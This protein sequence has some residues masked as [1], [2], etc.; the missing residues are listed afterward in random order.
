MSDETR[1]SRREVLGRAALGAFLLAP[2]VAA[3]QEDKPVAVDTGAFEK[4]LA[5]PLDDA[6]KEKL[7]A[8]IKYAESVRKQRMDFKLPE[9]SEPC[10]VYVPWTGS[11][12]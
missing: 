10:T 3:A 5:K 8:A 2:G 7:R 4:N 12:K 11:L 6:A 1:P 9:N